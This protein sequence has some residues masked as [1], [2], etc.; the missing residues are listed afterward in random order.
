MS[1]LRLSPTLAEQDLIAWYSLPDL[2]VFRPIASFPEPRDLSAD[3]IPA[4]LIDM[5]E[6][7]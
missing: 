6:A 1:V 5:Q 2:P 3:D 4:E 7:A